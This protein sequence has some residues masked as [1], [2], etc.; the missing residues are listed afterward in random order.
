MTL[1]APVQ[2]PHAMAATVLRGGGAWPPASPWLYQADWT[3]ATKLYSLTLSFR[4]DSPVNGGGTL[5]LQGL[6]YDVDPNCPWNW[7]IV[8]KPDH[9]RITQQIP[10]ASRSGT[11]TAAQLAA[12]GLTSFNDLASIT[13]GVNQN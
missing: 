2:M 6:D 10:R 13:V 9:T 12:K 3:Q 8:V 11:V 4:F 7:I 5:A 1:K